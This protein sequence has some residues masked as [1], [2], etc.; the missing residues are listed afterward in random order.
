MGEWVSIYFVLKS[1]TQFYLVIRKTVSTE[2]SIILC[3][4]YIFI[5]RIT[6]IY[7][8]NSTQDFFISWVSS[9]LSRLELRRYSMGKAKRSH[10]CNMKKC[11]KWHSHV[12]S[13]RRSHLLFSIIPFHS[14]KLE[15][16]SAL[17]DII[18][19]HL[20]HLYQKE[21][22]REWWFI[23]LF[24]HYNIAHKHNKISFGQI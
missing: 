10:C 15:I 18:S 3:Y 19:M 8:I 7:N 9:D 4:L 24:I 20:L 5:I 2:R 16:V 21:R 22:K 1:L 12:H 11:R 17:K 6:I 13:D 23:Y 14:I